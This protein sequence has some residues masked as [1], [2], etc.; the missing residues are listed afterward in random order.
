[1]RRRAGRAESARNLA[2]DL[3]GLSHS[4]DNHFAG[5]VE[6]QLHRVFKLPVQA[7]G[8]FDDRLSFD[9]QDPSCFFDVRH[10][11]PLTPIRWSHALSSGPRG[12]FIRVLLFQ[13]F[14]T[15]LKSGGDKLRKADAARAAWI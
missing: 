3:P 1:M 7:F 12:G 2:R 6:N 14:T 5:A 10:S 11:Q 15:L 13:C 4:G 8:H 9:L